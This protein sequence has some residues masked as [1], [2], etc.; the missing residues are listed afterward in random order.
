MDVI[1]SRQ[2]GVWISGALQHE[3]QDESDA[4]IVGMTD[5][6]WTSFFRRQQDVWISGALQHKAQEESD[7]II[8]GMTD[9]L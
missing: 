8:V 7:S 2:Q 9:D 4:I 6:S 3:A 1:F 5:D